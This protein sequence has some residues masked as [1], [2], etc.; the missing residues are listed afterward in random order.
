M[1]SGNVLSAEAQVN[2]V[3]TRSQCLF[4][5]ISASIGD[6]GFIAADLGILIWLLL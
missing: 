2:P 3:L 4:A 1:S 5:S 6:L